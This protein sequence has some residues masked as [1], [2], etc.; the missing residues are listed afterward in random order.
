MAHHILD[1]DGA[2]RS[3][4]ATGIYV[5]LAEKEGAG[6]VCRA[7]HGTGCCHVRIEYD[8]FVGRLPRTDI[9][10]VQRVN[11]G[12]IVGSE[13]AEFGGL[14]YD[15]WMSGAKFTPGTEDRQHT[16]PAWWY[17]CADYKLKPHWN[18]CIGIGAFVD[19]RQFSCKNGCWERWD[20]EFGQAAIAKAKGQ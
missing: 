7:C 15:D 11:P 12:V 2:C 20:Q 4:N 9:L 14:S 19:C 17:Q 1:Y 16:C 13:I 18:E 5:G 10:R 3:C 8:D 6:V